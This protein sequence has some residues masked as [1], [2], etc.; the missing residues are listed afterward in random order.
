MFM[1][2]YKQSKF[3]DNA[4][5]NECFKYIYIQSKNQLPC[6]KQWIIFKKIEYGEPFLPE[7]VYYAL[8]GLK[9][10]NSM[11]GRQEDAEEFLCFLLDGLHEEFLTGKLIK[12]LIIIRLKVNL[13]TNIILVQEENQNIVTQPDKNTKSRTNGKND[14]E[15]ME[16]GPRNK[17]SFTRTVSIK[18]SSST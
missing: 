9:R 11:K 8:R 15:W 10:F 16:V 7:Y 17:T 12:C 14:G 1:N 6:T 13:F 4:E 18:V 3:G 5:G 2:E